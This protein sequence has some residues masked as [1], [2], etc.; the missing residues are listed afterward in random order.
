M[1]A[2]KRVT[3]LVSTWA[4]KAKQASR[5]FSAAAAAP[6][7]AARLA[8]KPVPVSS[9]AGGCGHAGS[10]PLRRRQLPATLSKQ[11]RRGCVRPGGAELCR[12]AAPRAST[13][14]AFRRGG[15]ACRRSGAP[16]R[17]R[18]AARLAVRAT[19]DAFCD[20]ASCRWA[21]AALQRMQ[22]RTLVTATPP[23]ATARVLPSSPTPRPA[24]PRPARCRRSPRLPRRPAHRARWRTCRTRSWC[25]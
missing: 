17:P 16:T 23:R 2:A 18:A 10:C 15:A 20:G 19:A 12:R 4:L 3:S 7:E 9:T 11:Y 24:P 5:G 25:R 8:E 1:S 21:S 14:N 13:R 6:A 22:S